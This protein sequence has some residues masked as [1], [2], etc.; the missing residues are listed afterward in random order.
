MVGYLDI[1]L[2]NAELELEPIGKNNMEKVKLQFMVVPELLSSLAEVVDP[3]RVKIIDPEAIFLMGI[4]GESGRK[5]V[6]AGVE[7]YFERNL[8]EKL[9]NKGIAVKIEPKPAEPKEEFFHDG[10]LEDAFGAHGQG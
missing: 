5:L 10:S 7:F 6:E 9:I 3:V 2:I 1:N 4:L 8:A